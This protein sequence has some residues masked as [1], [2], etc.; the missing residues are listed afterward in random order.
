M[1]ETA[2]WLGSVAEWVGGLATAAAL[3]YALIQG[4]AARADAAH[5]LEVANREAQ[6]REE[7]R[8]DE[9]ADHARQLVVT[10]VKTPLGAVFHLRNTGPDALRA[11]SIEAAYLS[12]ARGASRLHLGHASQRAVRRHGARRQ[13]AASG[14]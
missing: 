11:L 7:V 8:Q 2:V 10:V 13:C 5:A 12:G 6:W 14:R 9:L 1:S 3:V 4:R